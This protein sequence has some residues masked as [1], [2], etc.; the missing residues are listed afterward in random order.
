MMQPHCIS[1]SC[2]FRVQAVAIGQALVDAKLLECVTDNEDV[3]R[4]EYA[5]YKAAQVWGEWKKF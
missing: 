3:F 1:F 4:D 5:L 2:H